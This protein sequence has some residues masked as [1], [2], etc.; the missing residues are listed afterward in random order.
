MNE[1]KINY[2]TSKITSGSMTSIVCTMFE[3]FFEYTDE[4][5][6]GEDINIAAIRKASTVIEHLKDSLNFD[7]EISKNL[8]SLYDFC[9]RML[10]KST[11]TNDKTHIDT[12]IKIMKELHISFIEVDKQD[13]NGAAMKNS[14]QVTA[15]LTYGRNDLNEVM[16]NS[17]NRGFLA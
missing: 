6:A 13:S 12:A 9:Q 14:Q 3:I 2:Y 17:D 4:A 1:E 16:N 8:F 15:G 11:Y 5:K 7:Y 10:A